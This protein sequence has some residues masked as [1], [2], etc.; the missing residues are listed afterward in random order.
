MHIAE[1]KKRKKKEKKKKAL[2]IGRSQKYK[3]TTTI[4]NN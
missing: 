2:P 3:Q 1:K 4:S